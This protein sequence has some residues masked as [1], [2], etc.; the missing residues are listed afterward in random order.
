MNKKANLFGNTSY[1]P[2]NPYKNQNFNLFN[3]N[4]NKRVHPSY[5]ISGINSQVIDKKKQEDNNYNINKQPNKKDINPKTL[6]K[7]PNNLLKAS[8]NMNLFQNDEYNNEINSTSKNKNEINNMNN[9]KPNSFVNINNNINL[10]NKNNNINRNI[11]TQIKCNKD[12]NIILD[13]IEENNNS[14]NNNNKKDN[15]NNDNNIIDKNKNKDKN[16]K[17]PDSNNEKHIIKEKKNLFRSVIV[18]NENNDEKKENK[19]TKLKKK[20]KE[21]LDIKRQKENEKN[22]AEIMDQLKCYIC[23]DKLKKPRMCKY[24]NRP[25]CEKCLKIWLDE[26]HKCGFCRKRINYNETIE[27][28]IINDIAEFFMKNINNE[29]EH[30]DNKNNIN[31]NKDNNF[32]SGVYDSYSEISNLKLREEE[33]ICQKHKHKYEYFCYQCN[34]KYCDKCL[35]V[36]NNSSKIHENHLIVPL[37]QLEK[38]NNKIKE[39]MEEYQKLKQTNSDID[40]LLKIYELKIRELEIE[41]NNFI[42]HIDLI[43]DKINQ[44]L[45][46]K[47]NDLSFNYNIIKSKI[48]EFANS[49]DTTPMALQNIISFQDYGQSEQIYEHLSSLNK[50]VLDN[51]FIDLKEEKLSIESFVSD[52][53]EFVVP[54]IESPRCVINEQ[55]F[56][57]IPNYDMKLTFESNVN[58]IHFK[59]ILKK[60]LGINLEKE[61]FLCFVIFKN[62]KYGC[63]FIKMKEQIGQ[64]NE[65]YLYSNITANVFFSFQDENKKISYKLYFMVYKS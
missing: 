43:K 22:K 26:K 17:I 12:N 36:C 19:E 44:D 16:N 61:K 23:I 59:I 31:E 51:K 65:I 46:N 53:I 3:N 1:I 41:K 63:E 40:N 15:K 38:N 34:Q 14:N 10:N 24:C 8:I 29:K 56:N 55:E 62:K 27:V 39:A 42:N 13:V 4:S 60:K 57:L 28:P 64:Q 47:I 50:Y 58:N 30:V 2:E 20:K 25:A 5:I 35:V 18:P 45:N 32:E 52:I 21:I 49:I 7:N 11:Q 33:N 6:I 37:A 48:D 54:N 9:P